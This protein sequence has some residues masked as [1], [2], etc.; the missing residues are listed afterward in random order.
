MQDIL[1][2]LRMQNVQCFL[3]EIVVVWY[4]AAGSCQR[5]ATI[6]TYS[7]NNN[8]LTAKMVHILLDDIR[9]VATWDG[10]CPAG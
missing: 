3:H 5:S 9:I 8:L 1:Q 2:I 10:L 7:S 4:K 6:I